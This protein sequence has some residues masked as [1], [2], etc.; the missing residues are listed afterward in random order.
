MDMQI[1]NTDQASAVAQDMY[2]ESQVN[3]ARAIA[4]GQSSAK[5]TTEHLRIILSWLDG[6]SLPNQQQMPF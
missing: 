2:E 5:P 4:T 1:T 3:E 6:Y